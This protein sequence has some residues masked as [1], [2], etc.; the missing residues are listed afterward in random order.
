MRGLDAEGVRVTLPARIAGNVTRI[1]EPNQR[2]RPA[3][4]LAR[5]TEALRVT[6]PARIAGNVTRI[7]EQ[8][9]R[10]RPASMPTHSSKAC[11]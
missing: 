3:S 6:L 11:V 8:N 1:V 7:V 9:Q 4:M 5:S 10:Q 2:Q